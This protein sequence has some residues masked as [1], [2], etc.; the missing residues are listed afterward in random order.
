MGIIM[1]MAKVC[2]IN[3]I[4]K[5]GFKVF[6][7]AGKNV[8]VANVAKKYYCADA[9]CTQKG[10]ML[11]YGELE[12]VIVKC[13]AHGPCFN[14][15]TGKVAKGAGKSVKIYRTEVRGTEVWADV[16]LDI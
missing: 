16:K 11:E 6:N 2:G 15:S 14:V 8:L 5:N 10:E 9:L 1:V 12:D 4:P 7:V 13:P 3:H